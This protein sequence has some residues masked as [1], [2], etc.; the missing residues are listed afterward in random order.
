MSG[1]LVSSSVLAEPR[2]DQLEEPPGV[3]G[4]QRQP[5]RMSGR[6]PISVPWA[7]KRFAPLQAIDMI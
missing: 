2:P 6:L 7:R 5:I 4:Q 1:F 3:D